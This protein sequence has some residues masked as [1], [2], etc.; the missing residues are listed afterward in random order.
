M[1]HRAMEHFRALFLIGQT[2]SGKGAAAWLLAQRTGAEIISLDSMK[3]YRGMDIGTAKPPAERRA[4]VRYHMIDV[5]DP[6]EHFSTALYVEGA[7]RAAWDIVVRGAVPLFVGG[8]A[9]Y[10][11]AITEGLFEGPGADPELRAKL[12]QEAVEFG[13]PHL[14]ERLARV[15]PEAAGRIHPND[16]RRIERAIEV[17]EKTGTPI[18]KLQSQFGTPSDKVDSVIMGL[19]REKADLEDRIGRRV[20]AMMAGGLLDEVKRVA[21]GPKPLGK[22]AA[23]AVGYKEI[24]AYL[25]GECGR[26]EAVDLIKLHT[27]QFA[28]AQMTW[29]KR[30]PNV[31]WFD[32]AADETPEQIA[33][34][35]TDFARQA[36]A[37]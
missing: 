31:E 18:S 20:D 36:R 30:I 32:V 28:K 4:T 22:E 2:A 1:Q 35:L 9:L 25:G 26:D 37:S 6:H 3:L 33:D 5:A 29:F 14:H 10:L 17:Y 16:L 15:D 24:L 7:E 19:R 11:K 27:R 21:A 12:R 13:I 34:R 23:Q 8:T